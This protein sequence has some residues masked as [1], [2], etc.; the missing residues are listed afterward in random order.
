[1][2]FRPDRLIASPMPIGNEWGWV[3]GYS[4]RSGNSGVSFFVT[5]SGKII[6]SGLPLELP[7]VVVRQDEVTKFIKKMSAADQQ[8]YTGMPYSEVP[9][10]LGEPLYV[11]TNG[12]VIIYSFTFSCPAGWL[13]NNITNGYTVAV[14]N[15]IVIRKFPITTTRY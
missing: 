2:T 10:L 15:D 4:N 12:N 3:V 14:E 11:G 7:D 5:W 6:A 9:A 13:G 8:I 1:M